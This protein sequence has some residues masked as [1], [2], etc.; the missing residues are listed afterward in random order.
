[1]E[2]QFSGALWYWRGPAPFHFVT[3]PPEE[4]EAIHEVAPSVTYGWG[5]IPVAVRVGGSEWTTS[6]WPKD[7]GYVVPIK[8][9]VQEAEGL[10]IDD[11]VAVRL[12]IDV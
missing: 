12:R 2:L 9:W 6:L 1:M 7:G 8:K 3:V 4:A 10:D 11:T 5:M